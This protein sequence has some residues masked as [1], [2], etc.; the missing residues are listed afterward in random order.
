MN[1]LESDVTPAQ[2]LVDAVSGNAIEGCY[3]DM[4]AHSPNEV[5]ISW[6]ARLT[7]APEGA[8]AKGMVIICTKADELGVALD[9]RVATGD[10]EEPA[11]K[12]VDYYKRFGF[13]VTEIDHD[14]DGSTYMRREAA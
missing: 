12:L 6:F 1:I 3:S 9:L 5:W 14:G 10:P 2:H 11:D 7:M 13:S 4:E 8:G